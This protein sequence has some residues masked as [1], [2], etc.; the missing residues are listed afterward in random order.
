[1]NRGVNPHRNSNWILTHELVIDLKNTFKLVVDLLPTHPLLGMKL[2]D[3]EINLAP[4]A[5]AFVHTTNAINCK[6]DQVAAEE[7]AID[8]V[9]FLAKIPAI[10]FGDVRG[11]PLVVW[12]PRRPQP[13]TFAPH[14]FA[15]ETT[16]VFARYRSWVDLHHLWIAVN[17]PLLITNRN[18]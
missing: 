9:K 13:S 6:T 11:W 17:C 5:D 1:M 12:I 2:G 15:D 16:F 18:R 10:C 7:V 14:R 3:I 8:R 4:H